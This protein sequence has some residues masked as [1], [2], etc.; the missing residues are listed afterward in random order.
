MRYAVHAQWRG[1]SE[2]APVAQ[3]IE[4][5]PPEQKAAGSNPAGGTHI[6][7]SSAVNWGAAVARVPESPAFPL[8]SV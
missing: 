6:T 1:P 8:I 5:L 3:G 2:R 7:S 4:R